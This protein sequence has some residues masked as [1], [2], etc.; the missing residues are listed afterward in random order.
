MKIS[1]MV[2]PLPVYQRVTM[3]I[4][5]SDQTLDPILDMKNPHFLKM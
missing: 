2:E 4:I 1:D 3:S 5:A